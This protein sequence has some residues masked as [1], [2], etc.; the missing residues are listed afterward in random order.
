MAPARSG[1]WKFF[2]AGEKQNSSHYKAYCLGCIESHRPATGSAGNAMDV[3]SDDEDSAEPL[4]AQ[5]CIAV[6]QTAH[7]RGE[8]KTMATHLIGCPHAS[9][10]AKK[11]AKDVK[12]GTSTPREDPDDN[13]PRKRK[14]V[15]FE[16]VEKAMQQTQLKVFKGINIPFNESQADAVRTQFCR[17]TTSANLPFRWT[18]DPEII[19]LF[20]M[21]RSTATD[22][23]PADKIISGRLLDEEAAKVD[24]EIVR[25]VKGRYATVSSDGWKDKYSVTGVD[26]TVDGKSYLIDLIHTRGKKK[27]GE[28]M[29][30]AFCEHI[31]K[32]EKETGC[33]AVSYVCDNDGGSQYGRKLLVI[34]QAWLLAFACCAHQGQLIL[35]DYFR[36]NKRALAI[37]EDATDAIGWINSHERVRDV[38]EDVQATQNSGSV[39][40]YLVANLTRWTTHSIAFNRLI[41]L[42]NPTRQAVILHRDAIIAAQVGA[43]KNKK[44]RKKMED[45]ANKFC[46]LFDSASFW[47]DLQTI[48]DDIEPICYITNINQGEKTRADQV[49]LGFAGV[50]LHF[51]KH[52]DR[53]VATGMMKRIEKRW[54][55]MDQAVFIMAMVL[56]PY[57]RVSRF[58]DQAGVS[59]FT[60]RT[61]LIELYRRVKSR[62]PPGPLTLEQQA[63]L[64]DEK[65]AKESEV[66]QAFLRYMGIVGVF[67]SFDETQEDFIKLHGNSPITVWEV[68]LAHP[69]IREL[70]DFAILILGLAMNQGGNERDFS[71]FKIKRTR[72]RNR[73]T[74]EKTGKMSKVGASI[75]REHLTAGFV[76]LRE[77]RKNHDESRVAELI[78]VPQYADILENDDDEADTEAAER[79]SSRLVN[80]GAAWRKVY[81]SWAVEARV[82]EM[83]TAEL[84]RNL[85]DE[86]PAQ[87]VPEPPGPT[88]AGQWLPRPFS[89]LFGGAI[90]QPPTR[91]PRKAFTRQQLLMELLAAEHSDEEPDDGELE[92]SG[93][94]YD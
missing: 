85:A 5:A 17:A 84:E 93:D 64:D 33:I 8:K 2:H 36:E 44:K 75:R 49:L 22:V 79:V 58:G 76:K 71:D 41:Q 32:A 68:M 51:K 70:A 19:K 30:K 24:A 88:R 67:A 28:S 62:P 13:G 11:M 69:D 56:N 31:D 39:L 47:K 73:L 55:A 89:R 52:P 63:K 65:Q 4:A 50:Y 46:D 16:R 23:M 38:F 27:D 10:A 35:V 92:G 57:E 1:V 37:A 54:A 53:A 81:T 29:C 3:D 43:E 48:A 34:L 20:L 18:I 25:A 90:P 26:I 77:G 7:V 21:F 74:F 80:S 61:V 82:A 14:R 78:A 86:G 94:D 40:A 72:L 6:G 87:S 60:L 59:V 42:K 9:A 66:S 45:E 12:A 83:E 91:A 15:E